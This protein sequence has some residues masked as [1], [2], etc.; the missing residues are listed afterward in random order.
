L[1]KYKKTFCTD[2]VYIPDEIGFVGIFQN[3]SD[4]VI[5]F[6]KNQRFTWVSSYLFN[7]SEQLLLK[8]FNTIITFSNMFITDKAV[9]SLADC[10]CSSLIVNSYNCFTLFPG[11]SEVLFL[12]RIGIINYAYI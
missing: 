11:C 3:Y 6:R 5:L 4:A 9:I 2:Y 12:Y 1:P 8:C 7:Y 10:N